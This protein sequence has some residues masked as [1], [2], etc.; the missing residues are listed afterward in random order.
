M[1][2]SLEP[3]LERSLRQHEALGLVE[4]AL[5]Q[6]VQ[7]RNRIEQRVVLLVHLLVELE[8]R[9]VA[10]LLGVARDDDVLDVLDVLG[11]ACHLEAADVS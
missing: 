7:L 2:Q 5:E 9:V 4:A 1:R 10:A 6:E 8:Q 11:V 3:L